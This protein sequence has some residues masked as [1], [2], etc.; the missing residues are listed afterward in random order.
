MAV[1]RKMHAL[2]A[3]VCLA[4]AGMSGGAGAQ[5][6]NTPMPEFSF[7]P[8]LRIPAPILPAGLWD[9][10]NEACMEKCRIYVEKGCFGRLSEKDPTADP[11]TIQD[12][13]DNKFS[14]CLYDCM[15][16]TCDENQIIIRP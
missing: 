7:S 8:V 4:L 6:I 3:G 1:W 16:D 9:K 2:A 10:P 14:L 11:G 5:M 15:C 13:C 12:K